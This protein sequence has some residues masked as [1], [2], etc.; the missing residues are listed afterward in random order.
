MGL[1][2]GGVEALHGQREIDGVQIVEDAAAEEEPGNGHSSRQR[3][4]I[5]EITAEGHSRTGVQFKG[6]KVDYRGNGFIFQLV[7][8]Y[9]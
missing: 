7:Q 1:K 4:Q 6:Q 8:V 9:T 2:D 5:R 3:Q